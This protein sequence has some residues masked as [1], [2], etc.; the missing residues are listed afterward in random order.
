MSHHLGSWQVWIVAS[1]DRWV[2][3][4]KLP[5][6]NRLHN[7]IV[8][9]HGERAVAVKDLCNLFGVDALIRVHQHDYDLIDQ[10]PERYVHFNLELTLNQEGKRYAILPIVTPGLGNQDNEEVLPVLDPRRHRIGR[11]DAILQ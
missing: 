11:C 5:L 8:D 10:L 9:D 1:E 6:S 2:A 4:T 7:S 3:D